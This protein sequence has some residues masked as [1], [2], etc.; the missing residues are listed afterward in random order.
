ML[1]LPT[2]ICRAIPSRTGTTRISRRRRGWDS[3]SR[4]PAGQHHQQRIPLR[5]GPSLRQRLRNQHRLRSS[6]TT[7]LQSSLFRHVRPAPTWRIIIFPHND[8]AI[9]SCQC[10]PKCYPKF[11]DARHGRAAPSPAKRKHRADRGGGVVGVVE[12][13]R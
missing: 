6:L 2:A 8:A 5:A 12:P 9:I 4:T 7:H 3:Q 13:G 1:S 10:K 11:C